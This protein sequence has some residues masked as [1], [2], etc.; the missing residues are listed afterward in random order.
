MTDE[1][2]KE[3]NKA[4]STSVKTETQTP[5]EQEWNK[6]VEG[7]YKNP[8]ELAKGYKELE[9][10]LGDQGVE[11]GQ[12]REFIDQVKPILELVRDDPALFA[13]VDAKL[14]EKMSPKNSPQSDSQ[15]DKGQEENRTATSDLVIARFEE[16]YG[17]D[18]LPDEERKALRGRIGSEVLEMTGTSLDKVDL[19]RLNSVLEKAYILANKEENDKKTK[20]E[21]QIEAQANQEAGISSLRSSSPKTEEITLTPEEARV[22]TKMGLTREQ[23]LEGKK[24]SSR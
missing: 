18:K 2:I 16:K 23:Y 17:I 4:P 19:R 6:I 8:E 15:P 13:A 3:E 12:A 22:A 7:K 11:V 1:P 14:K 9:K 21:A 24:K 10:K 5:A 20:L